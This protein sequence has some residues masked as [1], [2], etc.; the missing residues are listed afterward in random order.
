MV[1][2]IKVGVG[3]TLVANQVELEVVEML[4]FIVVTKVSLSIG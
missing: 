4:S 3:F 2:E 1:K